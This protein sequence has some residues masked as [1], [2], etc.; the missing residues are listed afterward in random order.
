M[1]PAGLLARPFRLLPKSLVAIASLCSRGQHRLCFC[2]P[3]SATCVASPVARGSA[4]VL[5]RQT[6]QA[7]AECF[8]NHVCAQVPFLLVQQWHCAAS[9][10][11][12][13]VL[14]PPAVG[15]WLLLSSALV[16]AV[17][18][19]G[20]ITRLAESGLSITEWRPITGVL[21]PLSRAEWENAFDKYKFTPEFGLCTSRR[22]RRARVVHGAFGA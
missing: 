6:F 9:C 21:L 7:L 17:I 8:L 1:L 18:V 10:S 11:R 3:P 12:S 5:T 22:A 2:T 4:A 14:S 19:V 16:I 13:S 15:N 20:G